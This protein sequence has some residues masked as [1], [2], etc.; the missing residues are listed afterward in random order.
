MDDKKA[1]GPDEVPPKLLKAGAEALCPSLTNIINMSIKSGKFPTEMKK[2]DIA[3]VY[4]K[5]DYDKGQLPPG[6]CSVLCL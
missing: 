3:P 2:A 5:S 1:T 4:K 6:K